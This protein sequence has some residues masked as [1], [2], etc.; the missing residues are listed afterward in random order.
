MN[1]LMFEAPS[2][3][4]QGSIPFGLLCA[5]TIAHHHGHN[6]RLIDLVKEQMSNDAL[7][8]VIKEFSP[9]LI[10]IGGITAG[11][12]N[13]KELIGV[14]KKNNNHIPIVIGGVI[15]SV[16]DLLLKNAG[17]DFI[18]HGESEI[19]FPNLIK[20]LEK[21]DDIS[22]VK[23]ISFLKNGEIYR[24][25]N[26]IQIKNLDDIPI[27]EYSLLDMDKYLTPADN[28]VKTYFSYDKNVYK[29]TITKLSGKYLFPIITARG[30]THKCIFCYRHQIGIRQ[31]SVKYITN[32]M[33]FLHEKYNVG[34]FQIND[35][36]TTVKKKWV[37]EFCDALI[38]ENL[39]IF[40]IIL[41]ARVDNVDEEILLRLK[42]AGCLMLNYGYESGSDTILKEIKKG[43]TRGQVLK[44]GLLSKKV[45]L[46]NVPEII[47]GFPSETEE[48]VEETIDFLKQLDTWPISVNTPI[49]FPETPLW[50]YGVDHKFINDKEEFVLNYERGLFVNF[51]KYS[52]IKVKQ[53][54]RKVLYDTHLYWLKQRKNYLIY[55]L[56]LFKKIIVMYL[57]LPLPENIFTRIKKVYQFLKP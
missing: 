40:F 29:E 42:K 18:V 47:I 53:F 38:R 43:V 39:G 15:T 13:C 36:L 22:I 37:L 23:G 5:S 52:D 24:T 10:G 19:S 14:I 45:G 32:L 54:A 17:A 49:P 6:V 51:T 16:S 9:E 56:I 25:E 50:Q 2:K 31:H 57:V 55:I 26:Q 46:K 35:E 11:Y 28:W 30:C 12:K 4:G 20:A 33:K 41:S 27:P 7:E 21:G 44:S 3:D 34:V 8:K 48:T 1:I